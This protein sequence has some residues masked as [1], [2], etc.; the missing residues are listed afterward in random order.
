MKHPMFKI[1]P[2][3]TDILKE[4]R[5]AKSQSRISFTKWQKVKWHENLGRKAPQFNF[6]PSKPT[7]KKF[8][9]KFLFFI[10]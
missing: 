10:F 2:E 7:K 5:E 6:L 8:K 1:K 4:K 3:T 9:S